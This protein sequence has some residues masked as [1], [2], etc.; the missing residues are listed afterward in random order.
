MTGKDWRNLE[1]NHK[2][3]GYILEG[4]EYLTI[5]SGETGEEL[6]TI[7]YEVERGEVS[8]W[9]TAMVIV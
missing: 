4:P 9:G 2:T 5:F 3:C 7:P 6:H 1:M 8:S